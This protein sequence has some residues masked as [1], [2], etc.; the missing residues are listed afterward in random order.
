M[1][2]YD[3]G[4]FERFRSGL[5]NEGFSPVRDSEQQEWTGP[6]RPSL[7]PLTDA[8]RMKIHFYPGWPLRYAHVIVSGLRVGH[9]NQGTICLWAEDDP[10][11][12]AGRDL[13][14]LWARLDHWAKTAQEGFRLED[15]ALDSHFLFDEHNEYQA[16]LPFGDL[17]KRG[18]NGFLAALTATKRGDRALIIEFGGTWQKADIIEPRLKGAFYLRRNIE[19]I[20]VRVA[21]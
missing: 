15:R 21:A 17:I 10:A 6:L 11:Q 14:A 7:R 12:I 1:K 8:N 2:T 18:S 16:E 3:D 9:A 19:V 5:V 4:A 13:H 20:S